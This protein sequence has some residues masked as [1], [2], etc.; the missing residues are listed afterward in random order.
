M[1]KRRIPFFVHFS[2]TKYFY[3]FQRAFNA[4]PFVSST[5][6]GLQSDGKPRGCPQKQPTSDTAFSNVSG[7]RGFFFLGLFWKTK[8]RPKRAKKHKLLRETVGGEIRNFTLPAGSF[9]KRTPNWN[10]LFCSAHTTGWWETCVSFVPSCNQWSHGVLPWKAAY[11]RQERYLG[12]AVAW[13]IQS[14]VARIT[15]PGGFQ[16]QKDYSVWRYKEVFLINALSKRMC[17]FDCREFYISLAFNPKR[18]SCWAV[19]V[20]VPHQCSFAAN[21]WICL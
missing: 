2:K 8:R 1:R 14:E 21:V 15:S 4:R 12:V 9:L 6:I 17:G 5:K 7:N 10:G 13:A 16:S 11:C 19:Y 18:Q 20:G 3:C